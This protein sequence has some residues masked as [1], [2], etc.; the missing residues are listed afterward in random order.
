[1]EGLAH[2]DVP[3]A[4]LKGWAIEAIERARMLAESTRDSGCSPD[5]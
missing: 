4:A 5:R 1:M 3:R 2:R